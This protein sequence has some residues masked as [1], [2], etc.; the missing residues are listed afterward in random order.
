MKKILVVDDQ[1]GIRILLCEILQKD[2]Y[3]MFEAANGV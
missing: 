2:G 1:Y 3:Q